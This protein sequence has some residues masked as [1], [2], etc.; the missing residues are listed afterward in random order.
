MLEIRIHGRGGQGA[1]VASQILASAIFR[2]GQYVQSFPA[3]GVERRGAP[4]AAFVRAD[5]ERIRARCEVYHPHHIIVMDPTLLAG[6]DVTHGLVKGGCVVINTPD[7]PSAYPQLSDFRVATAD[8][9]AIALR[10]R[11]GQKGS[12]IVNSAILGAFARASGAVSLDAILWAIS[13][14]VPVK[15]EGNRKAASEAYEETLM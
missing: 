14:K 9:G 11:L 7:P 5:C 13:E 3:F 10:H 1:V 12:P 6:V 2:E 15:V 4:V 8:A